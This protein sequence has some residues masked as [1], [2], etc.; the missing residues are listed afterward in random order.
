MTRRMFTANRLE[1]GVVVWLTAELGWSD[2]RTRAAIFSDAD[3]E[4]ARDEVAAACQ[5]NHILAAYEVAIDGRADTSTRER[6]R[7][8]RG[9]TIAPP[10]DLGPFGQTKNP[11]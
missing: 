9:P 11:S 5:R 1:D 8:G 10:A 6:I 7:A 4:V 3:V 2:R